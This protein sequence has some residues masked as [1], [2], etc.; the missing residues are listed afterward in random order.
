LLSLDSAVNPVKGSIF[1][2]S[3]PS[4]GSILVLGSTIGVADVEIFSDVS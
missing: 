1:D 4:V 2:Q 3:T